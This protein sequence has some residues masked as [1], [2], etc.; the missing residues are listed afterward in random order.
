MANCE[1]NSMSSIFLLGFMGSGKSAVARN[2]SRAL[3]RPLLDLDAEIEAQIGTTIADY[4]SSHGEPA[5]RAVETRILRE[6]CTENAV[7][8]LGGG[9][10]TQE[11][12]RE[13]LCSAARANSLVVYLQTSP[14]ELAARIRRAPGKRPLIDGDGHLNYAG[15]LR[16]VEVLMDEREGFYQECA[17]LVVKTDGRSIPQVAREIEIHWNER[18]AQSS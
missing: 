15:T 12:N 6:V 11:A 9:V 13:I 14:T 2:L 16:R 1:A 10:P 18:C 7:V 5:F 4:F 8:S 17:N 3:K